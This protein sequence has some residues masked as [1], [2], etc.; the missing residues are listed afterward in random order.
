MRIS[1]RI[2]V[3]LVCIF[4]GVSENNVLAQT[5]NLSLEEAMKVSLANN[6]GIKISQNDAHIAANNVS[7][8]N[9]GLEPSLGLVSNLTPSTGYTNQEFSTGTS[10]SKGSLGNVFSVGLQGNYIFYNGKRSL[11]EFDRLGELK[12]LADINVRLS[13]EQVVYDVM[14]SYYNI[15]RQQELYDALKD[16]LN[17]YEERA[18]LAQS[19]LDIGSGNKLDVF[20]TQSDLQIQKTQLLRQEQQIQIGKI[21]LK[22][23]MLLKDEF[24]YVITDSLRLKNYSLTE[25]QNNAKTNNIQNEILKHQTATA[26]IVSQQIE[27]Q[28][29]PTISFNPGV[30]LGRN[31]NNAG[32]TLVNQNLTLSA[33]INLTMPLYDGKNIQRQINNSKID[34]ESYKLRKDQLEYNLIETVNLQYQYFNNAQAIIKSEEENLK[35]AR[36]SIE[37]AMERFRLSRSTI[38]ELNTFQ[39]VFENGISR[40][41]AAKYDAKIAEIELLRLSGALKPVKN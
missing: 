12:N 10:V 37:I 28:K 15:I 38:L 20:Q 16:Q 21:Q 22:Q 24:N 30:F 11:L 14:R 29:K 34:L 33:N 41:V 5:K 13:I 9:A 7:R 4:L 32:L 23:L 25:L 18:R 31:D 2:I 17:Y 6:F 26:Y 19:R 35:V 36:Q 40:L 27:A 39:Q 8:G 1:I 3:S